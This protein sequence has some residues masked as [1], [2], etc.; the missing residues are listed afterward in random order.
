MTQ[1]IN[2]QTIAQY[3]NIMVRAEKANDFR[4]KYGENT[5]VLFEVGNTYEAYNESAEALHDICKLA[6]IYFGNIATADFKKESDFWVFPKMVREGYKLCIIDK[7]S[8]I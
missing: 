8:R 2:I 7:Q 4:T 1:E 3:A 6:L 5:I